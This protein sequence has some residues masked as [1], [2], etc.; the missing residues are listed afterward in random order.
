[1]MSLLYHQSILNNFFN[2]QHIRFLSTRT[3]AA[4]AERQIKTIK[5]MLHKRI[6]NSEDKDWEDHTGYALLAYNHKM[7]NR[8]TSMAP[9]GG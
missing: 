7:V 2:E 9:Y 5:D 1:M 6:E 4:F 3:H 8:S